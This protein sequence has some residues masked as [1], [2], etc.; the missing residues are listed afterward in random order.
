M[1]TTRA[2]VGFTAATGESMWQV[3]DIL[4][5]DFIALR[6]DPPYYPPSVVNGKLTCSHYTA[7]FLDKCNQPVYI[8]S[9]MQ[10]YLCMV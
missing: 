10:V 2:F 5:W 8:P 3:H 6:E 1:V 7:K 4:S 9:Y